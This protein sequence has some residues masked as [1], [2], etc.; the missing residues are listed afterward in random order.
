MVKFFARLG[1][2]ALAVAVSAVWLTA[3]AADPPENVT[4]DDCVAKKSAVEFP[5]KAHVGVTECS[6]CH[7]TQEGLTATSGD[8]VEKCGGCHVKP[9]KAETP[10]C[11]Q[12]SLSKNPYHISCIKCHKDAV[13]KDA[14]L[15]APTKCDACHPKT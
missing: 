4:I 12:M 11:A 15:K 14:T 10:A 7:H 5:H 8:T 9:E 3:T 2:V 13:K 1:I 6:T